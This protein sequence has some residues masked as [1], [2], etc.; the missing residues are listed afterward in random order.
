MSDEPQPIAIVIDP[1]VTLDT[2]KPLRLNLNGTV[3]NLAVGTEIFIEPALAPTLEQC[4]IPFETI[5][6]GDQA[7]PAA[8]MS[9]GGTKEGSGAPVADTDPALLAIIHQPIAKLRD[10]LAGLTVEELD[11]LHTAE[12]AEGEGKTRKGALDAITEAKELLTNQSA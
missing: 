12:I 10:S 2:G 3:L 11:A 8:A 9:D 5:A 4:G 1:A 6:P 7:S